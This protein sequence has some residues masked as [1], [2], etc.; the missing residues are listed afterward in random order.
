MRKLGLIVL[1]G[2]I[3]LNSCKKINEMLTFNVNDQTEIVV[4]SNSIYSL[5]IEI[6]TPDITTN[7]DEEFSNNGTRA[8]LVKEVYLS[9]LKLSIKD[10]KE[11]TFSFLKSI[12]VFIRT[13]DSDEIELAYK[14]DISSEL[15]T[16]NLIVTNKRLDK[17]IKADSYKLR[18]EVTTKETL[19]QD[20]TIVVDM[21]F[22]VTADPL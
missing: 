14:D 13:D 9:V 4:E 12:H 8:D 17:Y 10:P 21:S 2:V 16:F 20:V 7:S 6:P 19:T 22:K 11:K 15:K 1:L 18:T 3:L 5:P